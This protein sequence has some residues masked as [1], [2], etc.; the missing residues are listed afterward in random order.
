MSCDTCPRKLS[1]FRFKLFAL[2]F[3]LL[4]YR[5]R[6]SNPHVL[7]H[8]PLKPAC[9]RTGQQRRQAGVRVYQPACS[10][11]RPSTAGRPACWR[12][13]QSSGRQVPPLRSKKQL[14]SV[15]GF[16]SCAQDRTRTCT[17]VR[18]LPPQSS[19]STNFTTWAFS[20]G[21]K[22]KKLCQFSQHTTAAKR[23]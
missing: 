17:P 19:M 20:M 8:T 18:A 13:S 22:C 11:K 23:I 6:D 9:P 2:S 21:D 10:S 7:R 1:S 15:R 4:K 14:P 16:R 5:R 12:A 3:L